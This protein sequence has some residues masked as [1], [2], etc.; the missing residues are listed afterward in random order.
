ML[1]SVNA[2]TLP[3]VISDY[4]SDKF[5]RWGEMSALASQMILSVMIF[6]AITQRYL[7]SVLTFEA[8]K[9]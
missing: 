4:M 1:T 2:K 6:A 7:V 5:L 8:V 9:E 3:V